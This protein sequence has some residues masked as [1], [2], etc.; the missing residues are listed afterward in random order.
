MQLIGSYDNA[1]KSN[2]FMSKSDIFD[3]P[4]LSQTFAFNGLLTKQEKIPLSN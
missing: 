4:G 3:A 2:E 1:H